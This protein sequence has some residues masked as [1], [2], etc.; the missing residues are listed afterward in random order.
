MRHHQPDSSHGSASPDRS[1]VGP[2]DRASSTPAVESRI[3]SIGTIAGGGNVVELPR[4]NGTASAVRVGAVAALQRTSGNAAVQRVLTRDRAIQR[5]TSVELEEPENAI[6]RSAIQRAVIQRDLAADL[7][8]ALQMGFFTDPATVW[9]A[10]DRASAVDKRAVLNNVPLLAEMRKH[11]DTADGVVALNKL[12]APL[13]DQL[14]AALGAGKRIVEAIF[15]AIDSPATPAAQKQAVLRNPELMAR[16][17]TGLSQFQACTVMRKLGAPLTEQLL[18]ASEGKGADITAIFPA[19][20]AAPAD[21]KATARRDRELVT[22][23]YADLDLDTMLQLLDALGASM[24]DRLTMAADDWFGGDE[25][26]VKIID[27]ATDPQRQEVLA[28]PVLMKRLRLEFATK[29]FLQLLTTLHA[30]LPDKLEVVLDGGAAI[31]VEVY[32]LI[33]AATEAERAPLKENTALLGRL[34]TELNPFGFWRVAFLLDLP[35]ASQATTPGATPPDPASQPDAISGA[36]PIGPRTLVGKI[37]QALDLT[38]PDPAVAMEAIVAATPTERET[39]TGDGALR[40]RLFAALDEPSLLKVMPLLKIGIVGRVTELLDRK[41]PLASLQAMIVAATPDEKGA[42]LDDRLLVDRLGEYAGEAQRAALMTSL[43]D[44]PGN[45]IDH[46]LANKPTAEAVRN[47][48]GTMDA[49]GRQGVMTNSAVMARIAAAFPANEYLSIQMTLRYG[50]MAATP[51]PVSTLVMML[52]ANPSLTFAQTALRHIADADLEL[53]KGPV[54]EYLKPRLSADDF[55][56]LGRILDQGLITEE[57]INEKDP[58]R[59]M[60]AN[61]PNPLLGPFLFQEREFTGTRGF[62]VAYYR[63]RVQ[64]VVRIEFVPTDDWAKTNLS[65]LMAGYETAIE[66]SWD[67]KFRLRN[68][69]RNLPIRIDM[70][71]NSG[72]PHFKVNIYGK[73]NPVWGEYNTS[74][75]YPRA[76]NFPASA[77]MHEFGHMLG[78][79]DEYNLSA[80]VYQARV[81]TAGAT[82]VAAGNATVETDV[83]GQQR[84][85]NNVSL[86]G[87]GGVTVEPR[88]LNYFTNW[89]NRNRTTGEPAYTLI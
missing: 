62:D 10:I 74:N 12:G 80:A 69:A 53:I 63:D 86:M 11:L 76:T 23:L 84:F 54:R 52:A 43:G 3:P 48:I 41:A 47:L 70:V 30:S 49:A 27:G 1:P 21:Q 40:R 32:P 17:R 36:D 60:L 83:I 35:E 81:G 7:S 8:D 28:N 14:D 78:N 55:A 66:G 31:Q 65:T 37:N 85:T 79:P 15:A 44:A 13:A 89:L 77:P 2:D 82:D 24:S 87:G 72:K 45:Q 73:T 64:V 20:G 34:R 22:R 33:G 9:A 71:P 38:P 25:A 18:A 67:N 59:K 61:H 51:V 16:L 6:Q 75:W 5:H 58:G 19:I 68:A 88:H 4:G 57:T 26:I 50:S 29:E 56:Q 42:V 46:L 39:L